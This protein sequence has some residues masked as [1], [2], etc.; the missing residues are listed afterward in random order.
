MIDLNLNPIRNSAPFSTDSN[1]IDTPVALFFQELD[2]VMNM[3]KSDFYMFPFAIDLR[4]YVFTK[5]I[6]NRTI[7]GHIRQ[8]VLDNCAHAGYF[9]WDIEVNIIK[10]SDD[11][12]ILHIIFDVDFNNETY[13]NQF[14]VGV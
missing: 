3:D 12:D 10:G 7:A 14:V 13:T 4:K 9:T 8:F 11:K 2:M 1:I 5:N 6:S